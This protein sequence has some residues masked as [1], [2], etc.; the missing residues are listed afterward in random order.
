MAGLG[1]GQLARP[2]PA[3][4]T[5]LIFNVVSPHGSEMLHYF[6]NNLGSML[7]LNFNSNCYITFSIYAMFV[8]NQPSKFPMDDFLKLEE[9]GTISLFQSNTHI[10]MY[11]AILNTTM[12]KVVEQYIPPTANSM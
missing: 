4:C 10:L 12:L 8:N 3:E 7:A 1:E 2:I 9:G 11:N 5:D 6:S